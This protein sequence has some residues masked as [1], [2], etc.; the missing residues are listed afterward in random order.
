MGDRECSSS[1]I[2]ISACIQPGLQLD[3]R[4]V[5]EGRARMDYD[6]ADYG[7]QVESMSADARGPQRFGQLGRLLARLTAARVGFGRSHSQD[8]GR[9]D[10]RVSANICYWHLAIKHSIR[11]YWHVSAH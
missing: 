11:S 5:E 4:A 9:S 7:K 3:E 2:C 10:G 6:Q 8:L 1:G